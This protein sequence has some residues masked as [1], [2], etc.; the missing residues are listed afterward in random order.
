M[1]K[2]T[3]EKKGKFLANLTEGWSV[4]NAADGIGVSRQA[5]YKLR[6]E[7]ENFAEEWDSAIEE[8]TDRLEDE[9]IRRAMGSSDTLMIFM[10]KARRPQKYKDRVENQLTGKDGGVLIVPGISKDLSEWEQQA[11]EQQ[12]ELKGRKDNGGDSK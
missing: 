6:Q 12:A 11:I 4:T 7:D 3:V 8:G 9:A 5:L 2:L 1:S 10:L